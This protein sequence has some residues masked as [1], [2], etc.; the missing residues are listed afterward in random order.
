VFIH[1]D[2]GLGLLG[3][4]SSCC[5]T[6]MTSNQTKTE[7]FG[8]DSGKEQIASKVSAIGLDHV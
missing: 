7:S 6:A 5:D 1:Q 4:A 3:T 8:T 2:G